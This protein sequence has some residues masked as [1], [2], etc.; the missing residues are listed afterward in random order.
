MIFLLLFPL[1]AKNVQLQKAKY[2]CQQ[3]S[4]DAQFR[5]YNLY[6]SAYINA[7]LDQKRSDKIEAL[8]G[9]IECSLKLNMDASKYRKELQY[10]TG[11]RAVSKKSAPKIV[12]KS[13]LLLGYKLKKGYIRIYLREP[14]REEKIKRLVLRRTNRYKVVYDIPA[15]L[16]FPAKTVPLHTIERMKI[17]QHKKDVVRIVLENNSPIY[18]KLLIH[19]NIIDITLKK[20]IQSTVKSAVSVPA[21]IKNSRYI[22]VIDPG[23][24]GK[25]S[26]AIGYKRKKEKNLVL[27]IAKRAYKELKK[28]GYKVYLT[29]RGDYF[30]KLRNRTKFANRVK[31]NIFISIHANAAPKKSKYLSMHGLETFFLS[32]ARSARAKRI[33]ALENRVDIAGM[34][35]K[36]KDIALDFLNKEKTILSNKL[37]IDIQK[38]ILYNLRKRYN[39]KDGGVRPGPFWVLVGAQMPAILIEVGYITNPTEAM[40]LSN[41]IYQR[42]I[43][44]GIVQGVQSYLEHNE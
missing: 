25:D 24:G 11:Q 16:G 20:N 10:L 30:I 22:I 44:K 33:A 5:A 21:T 31:A 7:L 13:N 12:T 9:L 27:A 8:K 40:R 38:N 35:Y 37:A 39:V 34:N 28:V 23:H 6:K 43:A 18:S 3:S 14:V 4:K 41:P 15:R 42:L 1:F 29:R 36:E 2:Y 17:A 26:G 32:P 19:D